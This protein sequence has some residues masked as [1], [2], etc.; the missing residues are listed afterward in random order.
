MNDTLIEIW[1]FFCESVHPVDVKL[2]SYYKIMD[3][4]LS[5]NQ[6]ESCNTM[7]MDSTHDL[8]DELS[9]WMFEVCVSVYFVNSCAAWFWLNA[10]GIS[11]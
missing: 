7:W 11:Q 10:A 1:S 8:C 5:G 6:M 3:G 9:F 4:G 2:M